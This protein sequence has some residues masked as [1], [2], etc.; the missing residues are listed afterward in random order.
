MDWQDLHYSLISHIYFSLL[1]IDEQWTHH[2]LHF[3]FTL[4]ISWNNR[5]ESQ[6]GT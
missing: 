1:F 3:N 4:F 6:K 5:T 2:H